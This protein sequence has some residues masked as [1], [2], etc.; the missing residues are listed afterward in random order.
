VFGQGGD[1]TTSTMNKGGLSASSLNSPTGVAV[2]G[3][4]NLYVA[5]NSNNRVLE[6]DTPLTKDTTADSVFGQGG[7][8]TSADL[9]NGGLNANSLAHPLGVAVD[10]S[11]N[12][13]VTDGSNNRVLEYKTPLSTDTTA[14]IVLGQL[15]FSH[16]GFNFIDASGLFSPQSVAIDTSATPNRLYVEDTLNSRVLGYQDVTTFANGGAADLVIGQ[17]DFN[18]GAC[19]GGG[20]IAGSLCDPIGVA[21]D[22]SGNLYVADQ[23]NNRVLEYDTPFAGCGSFPC[24]GADANRV[25]GQG[26]SFTSNTPNKGG[27]SGDSLNLPKGVAV[28]ASGNLYVADNGNNRVLEYN[29]PLSSDTTADRVF[30]QGGSF[31]TGTVNKGGLSASS[32]SSPAGTAVDADGN[33]YVADKN[34]SRVLEYDQPLATPVP[35]ATPTS[36]PTLTPTPT[37]TATPTPTRSAT[38]TATASA[39]AT[40]TRSATPTA[41]ATRTATPTATATA[42]PTATAT[43]T[44]TATPTPVAGKLKISPKSLNFGTVPTNSSSTKMVK[45]TNAGKVTKK[46]HPLPILVEMETATPSVFKVQTQCTNDD[47]APQASCQ[48]AVKFTPTDPIKYTGTMTIIDNLGPS[49]MQAVK[50][51][52]KGQTPK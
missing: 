13:Y 35:T 29:T 34:N 4:G 16:N 47:L 14:D 51:S 40:A 15:D 9:N 1:F 19:D 26:G 22:A 48:I 27:V 33:L 2:D 31:S 36:T 10:A 49:L 18:S 30:G 5:D 46:K 52:G 21:L 8:F 39:T 42:T 24:V 23:F 3:S 20:V 50:L 44:P 45:V 41:T 25:F 11:D 43:A 28:D 37:R 32:L 7:S 38:P 17:P 12:L 6:Y